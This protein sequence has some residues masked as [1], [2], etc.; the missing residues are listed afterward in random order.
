MVWFI[1]KIIDT[2]I[3]LVWSSKICWAGCSGRMCKALWY[4]GLQA[5]GIFS[6]ALSIEQSVLWY[7]TANYSN[8]KMIIQKSK[9]TKCYT[10]QTGFCK[11]LSLFSHEDWSIC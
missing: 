9:N 4:S 2:I 1:K 11:A 3:L 7:V 5:N 6:G 8:I 10:W